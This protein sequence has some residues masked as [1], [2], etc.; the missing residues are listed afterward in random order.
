[1]MTSKVFS[2]DLD[3]GSFN[4]QQIPAANGTST[5][6]TRLM[7]SLSKLLHY[8]LGMIF[9]LFGKTNYND[10]QISRTPN[11]VLSFRNR[12]IQ[13]I[14][15]GLKQTVF[16][17]SD[18]KVYVNNGGNGKPERMS[19]LDT[20]FIVQAACGDGHSVVLSNKGHIISWGHDSK[21]Q[22][23][24]GSASNNRPKPSV[25]HSLSMEFIVQV[26]CGSKHT[27]ALAK[28]GK[29]FAWGDNSRLQLGFTTH[30]YNT[31]AVPTEIACL[32]G[33]PIKQISCGG[34]HSLA[35]TFSGAVFCWGSN[36][37][38]QLGVHIGRGCKF[39]HELDFLQGQEISDIACGQNHSEFRSLNGEVTI[40]S[41]NMIDTLESWSELHPELKQKDKKIVCGR[42]YTFAFIPSSSNLYI[43]G[44]Y[45]FILTLVEIKSLSDYFS[46]DTLDAKGRSLITNIYSG[47][48][49]C[50]FITS[51]ANQRSNKNV[52]QDEKCSDQMIYQL[53]SKS[54]SEIAE[55]SHSSVVPDN[56]KK[57]IQSLFSSSACLNASFLRRDHY[58]SEEDSGLNLVRARKVF[59]RISQKHNI[60]SE[61]SEVLHKQLSPTL[62]MSPPG[63]EALRL[64][65]LLLEFP[66]MQFP[67]SYLQS[68][69]SITK[70][71]CNLSPKLSK[72]IDTWIGNL[73]PGRFIHLITIFKNVMVHL[74][75][76]QR[77]GPKLTPEGNITIALDMLTK[78]YKVFEKKEESIEHVS[79]TSFYIPEINLLWEGSTLTPRS[80]ELLKEFLEKY[81]FI[82]ENTLKMHLILIESQEQKQIAVAEEMFYQRMLLG[83]RCNMFIN[84][85]LQCFCCS[86]PTLLVLTID[87]LDIVAS[88]MR[89]LNGK[90]QR[91]LKKK[92]RVNFKDEPGIDDGGPIKEFFLLVFKTFFN[93]EFG[94]FKEFSKSTGTVWFN[95]Q[96]HKDRSMF[97]MV[98]VLC[99]LAIYNQVIVDLPFPLVLYKK[100]LN[101]PVYL[102]DF[103]E[104]D[105]GMAKC[106]KA[107][108]DYDDYDLQD[109]FNMYFQ[110]STEFHED[111]Q[112]FDLKKGGKYIPVT[113]DNKQEYVALYVDHIFNK[114]VRAQYSAFEEGFLQ[115]CGGPVLQKFHPQEL[116]TMVVGSD[117][118]D[119]KEFE[120]LVEY[121]YISKT[122]ETIQFFWQVF[123]DFTLQEKKKFL[124]F[125]T[126]S[127]RIPVQGMSQ[128]KMIIQP[129]LGSSD[130]LPSAHTCYNIFELPLYKSK[131]IMRDK[132]SKMLEHSKGFGL[133]EVVVSYPVPL[134]PLF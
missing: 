17:L 14:A 26:S 79:Y 97:R 35:L 48:P 122:H 13:Q 70:A 39:P 89:Q 15:C 110:I 92:L 111:V 63:V 114:S 64:Y 62:L 25:I 104:L 116:K 66:T 132:L 28:S 65:L 69:I 42:W 24:H 74:L 99:G 32:S 3:V 57:A 4:D 27:L 93:P 50:Y 131:E 46:G 130:C 1:M 30:L 128:L 10:P 33:L 121:R 7:S 129:A 45:E 100:L 108:L 21:G 126:G 81:P 53:N 31:C 54:I 120:S 127:D 96:S 20:F 55:I 2:L 115:V 60:L 106:L 36:A 73:P 78:L 52:K 72:V 94:M 91:D 124:E 43:F 29:L 40:F 59:N 38:G 47:G 107:I 86:C 113:Y 112:T 49:T 98:G 22:C 58:C 123:H 125:L 23:G 61:I 117:S 133:Q 11:G 9:A 41:M 6:F 16:V 103:K 18:G 95:P 19:S 118:Y 105:E 88:T 37:F 34:D 82:L 68:I 56:V 102:T 85:G 134:F 119:W 83:I 109:V 80:V 87:R 5:N 71:L 101:R 8:L 90:L 51:E 76:E 75:S 67:E 44:S 77:D 84:P 12:S